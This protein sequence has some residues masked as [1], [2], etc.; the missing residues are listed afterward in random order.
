MI[1][2]V[3]AFRPCLAQSADRD[4]HEILVRISYRSTY[5]VDWREQQASPRVCFALY[6]GGNVEETVSAEEGGRYRSPRLRICDG[7]IQRE[8]KALYLD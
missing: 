2:L 7:G 6:S 8:R 1:L 3:L 5:G 4:S